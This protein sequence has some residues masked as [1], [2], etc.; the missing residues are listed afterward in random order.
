MWKV[1][2]TK[3]SGVEN[4]LWENA[5]KDDFARFLPKTLRVERSA[6]KLYQLDVMG[7]ATAKNL[8]S[9][10]VGD[11][12]THRYDMSETGKVKVIKKEGNE[13]VLEVIGTEKT[14]SDMYNEEMKFKL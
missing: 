5:H 1:E 2:V 8:E 7:M 14:W 13:M 6:L 3:E 12:K 4:H 10:A 9:E 11:E